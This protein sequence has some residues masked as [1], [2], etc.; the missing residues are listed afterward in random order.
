M[1]GHSAHSQPIYKW[2]DDQDNILFTTRYDSIPPECRSQFL[3]PERVE[4]VDKAKE[5]QREK[6]GIS[7]P[8]IPPIEETA[9]IRTAPSV[10]QSQETSR[11]EKKTKPRVRLEFEGRYWITDLTGEAKV[12]ESGIGTKI[13]FEEDL[14][15][16]DENLPEGR[17]TWYTGPNSK[18]RLTYTQ[19]AY[20]GDKNIERTIE[21]GGKTYTVGTRVKTDVDLIYVRLGW[22]WQFINIAKGKVK[23]GT[24]LEAKGFLVD[25]SLD[26]PDLPSPVEESEDFI[27]GLPTVGLALDINPHRILNI[28]AEVSGIYAGNYGY[29]FDGEA[30]VKIIPIKN[31][32]LFGGYR[33][34][35]LK[36]EDD[37]DFAKLRILG[38]FAGITLRF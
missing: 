37:P 27:G 3:K 22:A 24:L 11:E 13:D 33:L 5:S 32:S 25:I 20:S 7:S 16:K 18:L 9:G 19:V 17:F 21:F 15:I 12:T 10:S 35:D 2:V 34:L 36:A 6:D 28:F 14:G 8:V 29:L 23:L 26:A 31:L 38:P 1:L 4:E 30:G